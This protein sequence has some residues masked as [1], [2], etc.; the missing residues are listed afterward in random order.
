VISFRRLHLGLSGWRSLSA[1]TRVNLASMRG[2]CC[3]GKDAL[4]LPSWSTTLADGCVS[5][6]HRNPRLAGYELG[7]SK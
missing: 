3:C 7:D 5:H 4:R 2:G 1:K 6:N